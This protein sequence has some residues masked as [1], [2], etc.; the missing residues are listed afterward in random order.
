MAASLLAAAG[1]AHRGYYLEERT[2]RI[3]VRNSWGRVTTWYEPGTKEY[4]AIALKFWPTLV[5]GPAA[6]DASGGRRGR[7][8][9]FMKGLDKDQWHILLDLELWTGDDRVDLSHLEDMETVA[10]AVKGLPFG[11]YVALKDRYPIRSELR[12]S[13]LERERH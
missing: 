10:R 7:L 8:K 12:A 2:R 6:P 5:D 1:C 4:E 11:D 9:A 3:Y 13:L